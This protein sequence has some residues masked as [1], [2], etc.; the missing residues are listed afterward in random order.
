MKQVSCPSPARRRFIRQAGIG[1]AALATGQLLPARTAYSA[2]AG[3]A[4]SEPSKSILID[5]SRCTGCQSCALACRAANSGTA[6]IGTAAGDPPPRLSHDAL[7]F[8]ATREVDSGQGETEIVFVKRQCMHCLHPACV[9][10]CT[11]GALHKTAAGPVVYDADKCIGCRYCQYACPFGVPSYDWDNPL[12]LIHKCQ[13]C[14]DHLSPGEQ[15]A[16]VTACPNG[17][18]RYGSR[19]KLLAEAHAQIASNPDRYVDHVYGEVE[20]GGTSVLYL[21]PV[22]FAE[23][24]FPTLGSASISGRA[25]AVM[26]RTPMIALG[27]AAVVSALHLVMRRRQEQAE[28]HPDET[29]PAETESGSEEVNHER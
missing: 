26:V 24:G 11:V 27:V 9:A 4:V 25:E 22:P 20:A 16:C 13:M 12:G 15:P 2:S 10:A 5:L 18:L 1:L 28:F 8:V 7:S 21:S 14:T 3:T 17:A 6:V 23:L 29:A 19:R